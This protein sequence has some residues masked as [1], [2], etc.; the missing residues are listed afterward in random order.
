MTRFFHCCA[1]ILAVLML[2]LS[3]CGGASPSPSP[4]SPQAGGVR[5]MAM[6]EGGPTAGPRPEPGITVTVH[7]G[8]LHGAIVARTKADASGAFRV[9]LPPGIYALIEDSSAAVPQTVTVAP[10]RYVTVTLTIQ[11]F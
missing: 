1:I 4:T 2:S 11:A 7:E 9:D 6:I 10:G 3:A 5:G 8:D